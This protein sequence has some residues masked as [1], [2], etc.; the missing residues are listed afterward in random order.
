VLWPDFD[1]EELHKAIIE[2]GNRDRR[3]GSRK[4]SKDGESQ[5][6]AG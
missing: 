3:F 2:Y 6:Y 1:K 4:S 5:S